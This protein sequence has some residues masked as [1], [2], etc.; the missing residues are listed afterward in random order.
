MGQER[1]P[2]AGEGDGAGIPFEECG[3]EVLLQFPDGLAE[4][5]LRHP[6]PFRGA[7]EVQFLG[8]CQE[9]LNLPELHVHSF[10]AHSPAAVRP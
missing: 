3:A 9:G 8:H 4:G 1:V 10:A 7:A 6:E 5:R 2:S